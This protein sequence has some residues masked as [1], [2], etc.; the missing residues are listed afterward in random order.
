MSTIYFSCKLHEPVQLKKLFTLVKERFKE[1]DI[2]VDH[3]GIKITNFELS[4]EGFM[5]LHI[6]RSRFE[7]E[8]FKVFLPNYTEIKLAGNASEINRNELN[9]DEN[10]S[11]YAQSFTK[12][13]IPCL[14]YTRNQLPFYC[15][16]IKIKDLLPKLNFDSKKDKL[17][18]QYRE[19]DPNKLIFITE[20][21]YSTC[22]WKQRLNLNS[23]PQL[24]TIP[25]LS[26]SMLINLDAKPFYRKLLTH[27]PVETPFTTLLFYN[28]QIVVKCLS[29]S[30]EHTFTL[31][32]ILHPRP[33]NFSTADVT[34]DPNGN[35]VI[36]N[37][38]SLSL[39][40]K[41]LC[42]SKINRN[43]YVSMTE[44]MI[45]FNFPFGKI[46]NLYHVISPFTHVTD[47]SHVIHSVEETNKVE[48]PNEEVEISP[49]VSI[50][51]PIMKPLVAVSKRGKRKRCNNENQ[52][53]EKVNKKCNVINNYD[54]EKISK[55]K[56]SK[57]STLC[58]EQQNQIY[59][60]NSK[61]AIQNTKDKIEVNDFDLENLED[62]SSIASHHSNVTEE[63]DN[64][65][66]NNFSDFEDDNSINENENDSD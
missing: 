60:Y 5:H 66:D 61:N 15:F 14:Y 22:E 42:S 54:H 11:S 10:I 48:Q 37:D 32:S 24:I 50:Q 36:Q 34:H 21:I 62:V 26:C 51:E 9:S 16:T 43:C 63:L 49:S 35:L 58:N 7:E 17:V 4:T 1:L 23:M 20:S 2:I 30:G 65:S 28:N 64:N 8:D 46:G 41:Y 29:K 33:K 47:E 25:D 27:N 59:K 12:T 55:K 53:E 56:N 19:S 45:I 52:N 44:D 31:P 18:L 6:H 3:E 38:F 13:E 57:M 40:Q 39:M